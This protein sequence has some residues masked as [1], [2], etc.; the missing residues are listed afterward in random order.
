VLLL[1]LGDLGLDAGIATI[2]TLLRLL[3]VRAAGGELIKMG[4]DVVDVEEG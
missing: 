2:A 4:M 3:A 1:E